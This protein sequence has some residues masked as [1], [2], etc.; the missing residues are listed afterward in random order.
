MANPN[1]K[2]ENL[3][4]YKP[5]WRSGKTRTIRVPIAIANQVLKIA[6]QIDEGKLVLIQ[7]DR[8]D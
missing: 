7:V 5:K 8:D 6:H 2:L 3:T 1:P 4:S